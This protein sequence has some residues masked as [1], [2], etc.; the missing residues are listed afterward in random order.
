MNKLLLLVWQHQCFPDKGNTTA[1]C[2]SC[3]SKSSS[4]SSSLLASASWVFWHSRMISSPAIAALIVTSASQLT[5]SL[6]VTV[7]GINSGWMDRS[8][9]IPSFRLANGLSLLLVALSLIPALQKDAVIVLSFICF[10]AMC[11]VSAWHLRSKFLTFVW[12]Y[13][14]I[15]HRFLI[16]LSAAIVSYSMLSKVWITPWS[17]GFVLDVLGDIDTSLQWV[18]PFLH[19]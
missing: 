3:T 19:Q 12:C 7:V 14:W 6:G 8:S 11:L 15:V 16:M 18:P 5:H 10:H 1:S 2:P 13:C 17:I 9:C 4:L